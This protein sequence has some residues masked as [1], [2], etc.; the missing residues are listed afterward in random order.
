MRG[1]R[2]VSNPLRRSQGLNV[3]VSG[4]TSVNNEDDKGLGG[5]RKEDGL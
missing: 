1:G 2:C 5:W 3:M 4:I